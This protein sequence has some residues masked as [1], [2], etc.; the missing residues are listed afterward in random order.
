M[1][2]TISLQELFEILWKRIIWI[3]LA[4]AIALIFAASHSIFMVT[5]LYRS[6]SELIINT[7]GDRN[8]ITNHDIT[9]SINLMNTYRDILTRPIIL[10]EVSS[11]INYF[12]TG[13]ELRS[14]VSTANVGNSQILAIHVTHP[15]AESANIIGNVVTEVFSENISDIMG[16]F[17]NVTI[18]TP[19]SIPRGPINANMTRNAAVGFVGGVAIAVFIVL[20]QHFLDNTIKT[21]DDIKKIMQANVLG[22]IPEMSIEDFKKRGG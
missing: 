15:D 22:I 8:Y 21:D 12:Y 10:D 1:E 3:L 6:T 19:A 2:E 11:R 7:G 4:G 17:N 16:L 18:L 9:T 20:L 14:M 13:L 5:P